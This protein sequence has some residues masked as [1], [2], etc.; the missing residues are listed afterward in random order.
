[1]KVGLFVRADDRG[2]G[3][4]TWEVY[5]HLP[6]ERVLVVRDPGSENQGFQPHLDRFPGATIANYDPDTETFPEHQVREWL[7]GLDVVYTAETFYD[8]H[9][10]DW[11]RDQKVASV[12]HCNPEFFIHQHIPS[13][14][15]PSTWWNPTPWR[16]G[17]LDKGARVVPMPVPID[18]FPEPN[19]DDCPRRI[20]HVGGLTAHMDRNGTEVVVDVARRLAGDIEVV[21]TRQ[22]GSR[23]RRQRA[24]GLANYW[25]LYDGF[26]AIVLPRRYG[27]LCLP[28]N[29]ACGAG[30][31]LVM[32]DCP[33]NDE[34][35]HVSL[36]VTP[37]PTTPVMHCQG[38]AVDVWDIDPAEIESRIRWLFDSGMLPSLRRAARKWAED[39]SWTDL[40]PLWLNELEMAADRV[41]VRRR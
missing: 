26:P 37:H 12:V 31:A 20:L 10:A 29:E 18:R 8:W 2:L 25:E 3:N 38:G 4:Q 9:V 19:Y 24:V 14:P 30:M 5:R 21:V 15:R 13:M 27:G 40:T 41:Q 7:S 17:H 32:T 16:L 6:H 33:P 22:Q 1:M 34:W 39:R 23:S 36:G 28:A 35:P 11:C